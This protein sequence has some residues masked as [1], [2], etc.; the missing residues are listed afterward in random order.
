M[1]QKLMW[2]GFTN[3]FCDTGILFELSLKIIIFYYK[4]K[5]DW[6]VSKIKICEIVSQYIHTLHIYV[7]SSAILTDLI[8]QHCSLCLHWKIYI[9]QISG[10]NFVVGQ[11]SQPIYTNPTLHCLLITFFEP[12]HIYKLISP[13]WST[14]SINTT[15]LI[16]KIIFKT[17]NFKILLFNLFV[18]EV[19]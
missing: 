15:I 3:Y 18:L 4:N 5:L 7:C 9:M 12:K 17:I 16:T 2:D 14:R 19:F 8:N 6:S 1:I 11:P 13:M 10:Q